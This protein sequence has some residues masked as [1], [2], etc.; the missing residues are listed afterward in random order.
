M[1]RSTREQPTATLPK[2]PPKIR[3]EHPLLELHSAP[4][5]G[6]RPKGFTVADAAGERRFLVVLV[7]KRGPQ[8]NPP[9]Q[10]PMGDAVKDTGTKTPQNP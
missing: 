8:L 4:R 6:A 1:K 2:P 7:L 9:L 5:E 10:V 3:R